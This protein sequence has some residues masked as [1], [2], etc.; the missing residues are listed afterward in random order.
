M[1]A[2]GQERAVED[3]LKRLDAASRRLRRVDRRE[4]RAQIEEHLELALPVEP[5]EAEVRTVLDRLGDPEEIV[6]EQYGHQSAPGGIGA[7]ALGAIVLLLLGGFLAG[8]GWLVGVV[9]LWTS[10]AWTTGEKLIGT[11]LVP[12]GLFGSFIV[13]SLG[14]AGGEGC[15]TVVG[16][17][18]STTHPALAHTVSQ[19]TTGGASP[20]VDVLGVGLFALLVLVPF[21][22]AIFLARR[23]RPL[24]I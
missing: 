23:A 3:Y 7:Q 10:R 2:S 8:I 6:A 4:L 11:L 17:L 19:C 12:G 13:A 9:L 22:T 14:F 16:P 5:S 1:R 20:G 21:A 15:P 24:A 18:R